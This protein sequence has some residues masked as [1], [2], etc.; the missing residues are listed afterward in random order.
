MRIVE[1]RQRPFNTPLK[2]RYQNPQSKSEGTGKTVGDTTSSNLRAKQTTIFAQS[3]VIQS[4][5]LRYEVPAALH[6]TN[7][8]S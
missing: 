5:G 7:S 4:G 2:E 3:K 8:R 6:G 1:P